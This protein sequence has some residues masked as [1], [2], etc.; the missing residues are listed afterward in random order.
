MRYRL[1]DFGLE[2]DIELPEL[3]RADDLEPA[4]RIVRDDGAEPGAPPRWFRTVESWRDGPWVEIGREGAGF[5]LRFTEG[6]LVRYRA[7]ELRW[8]LPSNGDKSAIRHVLLDQAL[9]LV[10]S[11]EGR[12][13]LHGACVWR[14]RSATLLLGPAGAGKSTLAA[15]LTRPGDLAVADDAVAVV[16]TPAGIALCP[17]YAG[18]RLWPD[19]SDA[20]GCA[21]AADVSAG[22]DKRRLQGTARAPAGLLLQS[23]YLVVPTAAGAAGPALRPMSRREAV[24]AL[25]R[26]AYV[27]DTEDRGRA[28]T[29]FDTLSSIAARVP[30]RKLVM[31]RRFDALSEV[32]GLLDRDLA[33]GA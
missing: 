14:G 25:V 18:L 3:D 16:P 23:M 33:L 26:N 12:T 15:A 17:S 7:R 2:S 20:L 24:M 8:R 1:F 30:L 32:H 19:S 27:L 5:V 10:V 6:L 22:S 21:T 31:P 29:H 13:V 9:P 28:A 11:H 4:L